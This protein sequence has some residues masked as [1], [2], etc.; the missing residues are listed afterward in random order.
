MDK[1]HFANK[2]G[3]NASENSSL[4]GSRQIGVYGDVSRL[5]GQRYRFSGTGAFL[6]KEGSFECLRVKSGMK[7]IFC[8]KVLA[9]N[10]LHYILLAIAAM[11]RRKANGNNKITDRRIPSGLC[12]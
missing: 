9:V 7:L 2:L 11:D 4:P 5:S 8:K 10:I 6:G 1:K 12:Q 3:K